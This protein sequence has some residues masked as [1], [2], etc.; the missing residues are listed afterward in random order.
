MAFGF[1]GY[2]L[3]LSLFFK[4]FTCQLPNTDEYYVSDFLKKMGLNSSLSY[5]FSA[6]VCSWEGSVIVLKASSLGLSGL[7]PDITI[8][9]LTKLQYLDLSNNKITA[10]QGTCLRVQL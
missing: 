2:L 3:I 4:H 5:N 8:G 1:F 6:S 10:F 7:I 9:K